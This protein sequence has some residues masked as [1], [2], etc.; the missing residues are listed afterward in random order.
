MVGMLAS[1]PM[2]S[3]LEN[4]LTIGLILWLAIKAAPY[5]RPLKPLR[6]WKWTITDWFDTVFWLSVGLAIVYGLGR[7]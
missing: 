5:V 3:P 7:D 4:W 2:T 6:E 1:F